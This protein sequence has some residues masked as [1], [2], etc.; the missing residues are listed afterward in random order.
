MSRVSSFFV[1][2]S[3]GA[4]LLSACGG[5]DD[6]SGASQSEV[7]LLTHDSWAAPDELLAE[8]ETESGYR[9]KVE[10]IGD[11][12]ELVNKLVLTKGSPLG[13]VV[14][15]IDNT[16]ATRALDEDVLAAYRA[17]SVPTGDFDVPTGADSLTPISWGDVCINID[18]TWFADNG[19]TPP[20]TLDDLVKPAYKDLTVVSGAAT[21]SP[22]FAFLLA[23]IGTYGDDWPSYWGELLNNGA[24]LT[25]GWSDA[26]YVDFTQGGDGGS[27]PIVLS[28]SSSPP[29]TIPEGGD[30]PTT[31]AL[32][33]TCFRQVEYAGVLE[34][35][36]NPDGAQAV[37]DF[38]AS[39]AFQESLPDNMYVFPVDEQAELPELWAQWAKPTTAPIQVD[40]EQIASQRQEWLTEWSDIISR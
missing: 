17:D 37:V 13:D 16:F 29:F 38:L 3:A 15:G 21:S 31:S 12:G 1:F 14:Y 24:K 28:Y 19:V 30:T 8:F 27:R 40:P 10:S 2:L 39:R 25:S 7:V 23:T 32:L 18:D 26:Y 22:G 4:L 5:S 11:A 34:G 35:A 9:L 20:A 33:D 6:D 36:K